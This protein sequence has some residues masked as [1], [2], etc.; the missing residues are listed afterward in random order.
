VQVS[1]SI[2]G[3]WHE[4]TEP[5]VIVGKTSP[6][7]RIWWCQDDEMKQ[8]QLKGAWCRQTLWMSVSC[9]R[10]VKSSISQVTLRSRWF[11]LR[12]GRKVRNQR[13]ISFC[14]TYLLPNC[15]TSYLTEIQ[16][17]RLGDFPNNSHFVMPK[18]CW[19]HIKMFAA[20]GID[21]WCGSCKLYHKAVSLERKNRRSRRKSCS[22]KLT[23]CLRQRRR[24]TTLS[25][26][27]DLCPSFC[28]LQNIIWDNILIYGTTSQW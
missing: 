15:L 10:I 17:Q 25:R 14:C 18:F 1:R 8:Q 2:V 13:C 11:R 5:K 22:K 6:D 20:Q 26:Y 28:M 21:R 19:S 27:I 12:I 4:V 24:R 9:R 23:S 3:S 16:V 7:I